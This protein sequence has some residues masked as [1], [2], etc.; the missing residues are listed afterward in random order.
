[1][2]PQVIILLN[3][4]QWNEGKD[5]YP[6]FKDYIAHQYVLIAHRPKLSHSF[7]KTNRINFNDKSIE[8]EVLSDDEYTEI[9][10]MKEIR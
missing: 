7:A 6:I 9:K 2:A 8:M 3:Q 4:E 1:M 10:N 5:L